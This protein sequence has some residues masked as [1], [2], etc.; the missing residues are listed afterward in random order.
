MAESTL[1]RYA[2][3]EEA[4]TAS[5][6]ML[7]PMADTEIVRAIISYRREAEDARDPRDRLSDRNM[8]AYFSHLDRN[9]QVEGQSDEF[10]PKVALGV[11][12]TSAIINRGLTGYG[13]WFAVD[14]QSEDMNDPT[15]LTG[16]AIEK[17]MRKHLEPQQSSMREMP[18]FPTTI[19]DASKVG[20]L[21]A[22]CALKIWGEEVPSKKLSLTAMPVYGLS[23][24]HI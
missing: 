11:D 12:Q 18:S 10:L 20:L 4:N 3:P 9:T 7:I 2:P 22:M 1:G 17:L 15:R 16:E 5:D 6:D 19:T 14:L 21:Q 24:I 23:L 13:Q 8:S